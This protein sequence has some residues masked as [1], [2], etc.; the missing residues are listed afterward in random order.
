M[1]DDYARDISQAIA[2]NTDALAPDR[3]FVLVAHSLAGRVVLHYLAMQLREKGALPEA[4]AGVVFM[5][6]VP[7]WGVL[8]STAR[9][10]FSG[11]HTLPLLHAIFPLPR[12]KMERVIQKWETAHRLFRHTA[13]CNTE[14]ERIELQQFRDR[15]GD[16]AIIGWVQTLGWTPIV[17]R[18]VA[19]ALQERRIPVLA[20]GGRGDPIISEAEVAQ[21]ARMYGAEIHMFPNMCHDLMLDARTGEVTEYLVKWL[22]RVSIEEGT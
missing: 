15:L 3:P 4:L 21:T 17:C 2:D 22:R 11:T 16:E 5:S 19:Q 6:A 7:P 20:L 18:K 8:L 14:D 13:P 1:L 12:P 9:L 10:L